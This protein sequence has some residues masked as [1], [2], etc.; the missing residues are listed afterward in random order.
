MPSH[1]GTKPAIVAQR[2]API[3]VNFLVY[4][5]T[6][7]AA[8]IDYLVADAVVAPPEHARWYT[9]KL[10]YLP[11]T[12]QV[13]LARPDRRP[14]PHACEHT[15]AFVFPLEPWFCCDGCRGGCNRCR[16][17]WDS[18]SPM[19]FL[20]GFGTRLLRRGAGRTQGM[21]RHHQP[22]LRCKQTCIAFDPA[23]PPPP[24]PLPPPLSLWQ[25]NHYSAQSVAR[26]DGFIRAGV[27]AS[28]T[29]PPP[30]SPRHT[31]SAGGGSAVTPMDLLGVVL[32]TPMDGTEAPPGGACHAAGA[33]PWWCRLLWQGQGGCTSSLGPPTLADIAPPLPFRAY[34]LVPQHTPPRTLCVLTRPCCGRHRQRGILAGCSGP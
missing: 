31:R 4:P 17:G 1:S 6:S 5:G 12:Y 10:V 18:A 21:C 3:Q 33:Y 8:Y 7:G 2:P 30:P 15:A 26:V 28:G 13:R 9:E 11:G 23:P 19:C 14:L 34:S 29:R 20:V 24:S 25:V 32:E 16:C 22:S 27:Q